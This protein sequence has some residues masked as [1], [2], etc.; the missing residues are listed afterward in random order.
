MKLEL[1]H[2]SGYLPYGLKIKVGITS[3]ATLT[4]GVT[5]A[6]TIGIDYLLTND[7]Y[8]P[9]LKPLSLKVIREIFRDL[10]LAHDVANGTIYFETSIR[11]T[12]THWY[13]KW[14]LDE[15]YKRHVDI[16]GLIKKG[17]AIDINT[18][19]K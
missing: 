9:I 13:P 11:V 16:S 19:N 10:D 8:K 12:E 4:G 1:K 18:L 3:I 7:A 6:E 15:C 17:L 2:I 14:L 5:S